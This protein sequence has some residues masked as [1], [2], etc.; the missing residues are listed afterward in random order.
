M[1]KP[2]SVLVW[3][4]ASIAIASS[5]PAIAHDCHQEPRYS[6]KDGNHWHAKGTCAVNPMIKPRPDSEK[7]ER[8][9]PG[10]QKEPK[11]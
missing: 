9:S 5:I 2:L 6:V 11:R 7:R 3:L 8:G 4:A 1:R 10:V